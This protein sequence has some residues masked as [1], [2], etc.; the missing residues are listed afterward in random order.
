LSDEARQT[1]LLRYDIRESSGASALNQLY[2]V[3]RNPSGDT[4]AD[5]TLCDPQ[6]GE[7]IHVTLVEVYLEHDPDE[8]ATFFNG[9]LDTGIR[10]NGHIR[11]TADPLGFIG[12]A[13]VRF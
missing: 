8:G 9:T 1:S 7:N 5:L 4:P 2:Q 6:N 3:E 12:S 10:I 11:P 13:N